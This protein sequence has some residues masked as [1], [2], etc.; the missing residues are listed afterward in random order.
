MIKKTI[1]A[2][3]AIIVF[4]LCLNYSALSE[5]G[6]I[7]NGSA[8]NI[9]EL[10]IVN[11][12]DLNYGALEAAIQNL[13]MFHSDI[14]VRFIEM[15]RQARNATLMS[16]MK[17]L[18]IFFNQMSGEQVLTEVGAL[19]DLSGE[20]R[21]NNVLENWI[22]YEAC[23][24]QD[25][26]FGIPVEIYAY[27]ILP[28]ES[29]AQYAIRI[30]WTTAEWL[31]V[32]KWAEEHQTD[33]DYDG[34]QDIWVF[35]DDCTG[36]L[37]LMQYEAMFDDPSQINYDTEIFRALVEQYKRCV[38]AGV[39]LDMADSSADP[40]L[41]LYWCQPMDINYSGGFCALPSIDGET[42]VPA[43]V[44][45]FSIGK[46]TDNYEEAVELLANYITEETQA[47]NYMIGF[48]PNSDIYPVYS[49]MTD[50]ER[51]ALEQRKA[52]IDSSVCAWRNMDFV[53]L[54]ASLLDK[55]LSGTITTE[56]LV[57]QLQEKHRMTIWG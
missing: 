53:R 39:Y 32:L 18:D 14:D 57:D 55:Y 52:Y 26:C 44:F 27:A 56:E 47:M 16:G 43:G 9:M 48:A 45:S 19:Y 24:W 4:I 46:G 8:E 33:L 7:D 51:E 5:T 34:D 38:D 54:S 13:K 31:D 6:I 28:N 17:G 29:L 49:E 40:S 21:L 37:W 50:S 22:G 36:P 42:V 1:A 3:S 20:E 15:N 30:D 12:S 25:V 11:G 35:F 23:F 10:T 41:A 2:F